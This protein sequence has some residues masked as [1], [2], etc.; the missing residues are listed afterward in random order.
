MHKSNDPKEPKPASEPQPSGSPLVRF[1]T[2][3]HKLVI[4]APSVRAIYLS[5]ARKPDLAT[6]APT[7]T[8]RYAVVIDGLRVTNHLP[9]AEAEKAF[10][11]TVKRIDQALH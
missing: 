7:G 4:S 11:Q 3:T 8:G 9:A 5:E 10:D 6:G 1:R 2:G